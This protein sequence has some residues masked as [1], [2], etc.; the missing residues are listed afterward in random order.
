MKRI[1]VILLVVALTA[2]VH[3]SP[4]KKRAAEEHY[5]E[6]IGYV[7]GGETFNECVR[8]EKFRRWH[9]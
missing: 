1:I 2:C 8:A 3:F 9:R 7:W 6:K 5:C 4:S